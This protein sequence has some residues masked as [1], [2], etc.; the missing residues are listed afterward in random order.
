MKVHNLK[1]ENVDYSFND[2]RRYF[3]DNYPNTVHL[4]LFNGWYKV[5]NNDAFIISDLFNYKLFDDNYSSYLGNIC[6]GF[7]KDIIDKVKNGLISHKINYS[8]VDTSNY[9]YEY[10]DFEDSNNYKTYFDSIEIVYDEPE[11]VKEEKPQK[12]EFV[13]VGDS[14]SIKN[15][16]T[17][18]IENYTI[19]PTY[20][21]QKPVGFSVK[22]GNDFGRILYED[23]LLSS[24]NLDNNEILSESDLAQKLIGTYLDSKVLLI[25]DNLEECLY[26]II[27][28]KKH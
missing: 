9:S 1:I 13:Q 26:Q 28:I 8:I 22:R 5:Y 4:Y 2:L 15:L 18:E 25:D 3:L 21:T 6:C 20:H 7:P 16:K 19:L 10:C 23:E 12:F 24:S 11:Q 17:G 14:V 27:D